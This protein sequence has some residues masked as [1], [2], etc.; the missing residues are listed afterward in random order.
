MSPYNIIN[1]KY[2]VHLTCTDFLPNDKISELSKFKA[3]ADDKCNI[4]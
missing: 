3:F 2:N 4:L 1:T